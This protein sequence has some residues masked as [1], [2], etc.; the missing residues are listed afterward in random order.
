MAGISLRV[1]YAALSL[2]CP[3]LCFG[4]SS[5]QRDNLRSS[6]SDPPD[7]NGSR[8][9]NPL[10]RVG[11]HGLLCFNDWMGATS[12]QGES[13]PQ[14]YTIH[15]ICIWTCSCSFVRGLNFFDIICDSTSGAINE[16]PG[17]QITEAYVGVYRVDYGVR[18]ID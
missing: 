1:T 13:G 18:C 9:S 8:W 10:F 15:P 4:R 11:Y 12:L 2:L 5:D 14:Y 17:A 16:S 6:R 7:R 3:R